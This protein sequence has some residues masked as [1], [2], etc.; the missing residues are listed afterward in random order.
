M[1][2]CV[3]SLI[4]GLQY[5]A[6]EAVFTKAIF[7]RPVLD[8]AE[9]SAVAP[10]HLHAGEHSEVD[11]IRHAVVVAVRAGRQQRDAGDG[12]RPVEGE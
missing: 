12:R 5:I 7:A 1:H 4:T 9:L 2:I 3:S 8:H 6:W 11:L 10:L